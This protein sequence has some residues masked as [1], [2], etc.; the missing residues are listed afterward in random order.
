MSIVVQLL[1]VRGWTRNLYQ[2]MFDSSKNKDTKNNEKSKSSL[3]IGQPKNAY[4]KVYT[5]QP[6]ITILINKQI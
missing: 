6:L 5:I 2:R 4:Y 1:L 3:I